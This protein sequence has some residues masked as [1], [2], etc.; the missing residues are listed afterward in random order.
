MPACNKQFAT[1]GGATRPKLCLSLQC[2]LSSERQRSPRLRQAAATLTASVGQCGAETEAFQTLT[3]TRWQDTR[4]A[5]RAGFNFKTF[6][7]RAEVKQK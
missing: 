5:E 1:S 4:E 6:R 2:W 3:T 7:K